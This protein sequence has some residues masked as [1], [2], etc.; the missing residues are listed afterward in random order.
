MDHNAY[1]QLLHHITY[2]T[3]NPGAFAD[4]SPTLHLDAVQAII[5]SKQEDVFYQGIGMILYQGIILEFERYA[6]NRR[7]E[8]RLS[9][10]VESWEQE[11]P[12]RL[13]IVEDE[14]EIEEVILI[15]VVE[16]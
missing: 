4:L 11:G 13:S 15:D 8:L 12:E 7:N 5:K 6:E 1:Y 9:N 10:A 3:E 14:V 16:E 2:L